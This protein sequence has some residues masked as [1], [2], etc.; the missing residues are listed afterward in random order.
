VFD[1][2]APTVDLVP[3]RS[4]A[5]VPDGIYHLASQGSDHQALFLFDRDRV[6]LLERLAAV[7]RRYELACI[8]YCL[9]GN[10]YHLVLHTPDGRIS[11]AMQALNG[12]YSRQFNRAHGRSSH[13][14]RNR[15]LAKEIENEPYLLTACRYVVRNPVRAGLCRDPA[16]WPW[17]S[18]RATA[19]LD[20]VPP[21]LD[22]TLI[23]AACGGD[24]M[25]R[26][27]YRDF[28][29]GPAPTVDEMSHLRHDEPLTRDGA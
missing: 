1:D 24:A 5:F 4:R 23:S 18:Y 16:D 13:L 19:G 12:G 8:A 3:R 29:A 9:M 14:F 20:P 26:R 17:S 28:V 21:F 7:V 2:G 11:A 15:F 10:H 22:E 6:A 25:W 27:R